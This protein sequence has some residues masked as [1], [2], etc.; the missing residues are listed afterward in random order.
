MERSRRWSRA[1]QVEALESLTLLSGLTVPG[2]SP[3]LPVPVLTGSIH[4]AAATAALTGTARG[5]YSSTSRNPD[6]GTTYY[7][8]AA[9]NLAGLGGTAVSGSMRTPGFV[10]RGQATGTLTLYAARGTITLHLVGP[11]QPGFI[12]LPATLSYTIGGGTRA[13]RGATGSG[14]VDLAL[15]PVAP[16]VVVGVGQVTLVFH[17]GATLPA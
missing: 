14:T 16:K 13:Y 4:A 6:T 5:V 1:P 8:N 2:T 7:I 3:V 15:H 12:A 9:G 11:T 10:A 17:P